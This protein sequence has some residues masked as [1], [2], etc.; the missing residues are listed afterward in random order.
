M[1]RLRF[2]AE[3]GMST[4]RSETLIFAHASAR[5]PHLAEDIDAGDTTQTCGPKEERHF[6]E[7]RLLAVCVTGTTGNSAESLLT[8]CRLHCRYQQL[9]CALNYGGPVRVMTWG[10]ECRT[11]DRAWSVRSHSRHLKSK[12]ETRT[13]RIFESFRDIA[14]RCATL[15]GHSTNRYDQVKPSI[16]RHVHHD[17]A[18]ESY[19]S[20]PALRT[21][22]HH[23][24]FRSHARSR[25]PWPLQLQH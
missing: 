18:T 4:D 21:R 23:S 9:V 1:W 2:T 17:L 5:T 3:H 8:E 19:G 25:V 7:M 24:R 22:K 10:V 12:I 11:P 16:C 15:L 13:F 20:V 6:S 14:A